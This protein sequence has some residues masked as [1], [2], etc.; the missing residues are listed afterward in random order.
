MKTYEYDSLINLFL[1]ENL[2][3]KHATSENIFQPIAQSLQ[4][5][6]ICKEKKNKGKEEKCKLTHYALSTI[7]EPSLE[8]GL[9][10]PWFRGL[11]TP[12]PRPLKFWDS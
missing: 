10:R 2:L 5:C 1:E 9:R 3:K 4:H 8:G 6:K 11:Y 7:A 12:L